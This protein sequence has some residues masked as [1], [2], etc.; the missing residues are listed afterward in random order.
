MK[1]NDKDKGSMQLLKPLDYAK[2]MKQDEIVALIR[3]KMSEP[4]LQ[5]RWL[6]KLETIDVA[7]IE[8]FKSKVKDPVVLKEL[9]EIG[10]I[11]ASELGSVRLIDY[12]VVNYNVNINCTARVNVSPD[13]SASLSLF[14]L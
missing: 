12:F 1:E 14:N 4:S 7:R 11:K 3:K 8:N 10:L 6:K 13:L 2:Y 5:E 9:L